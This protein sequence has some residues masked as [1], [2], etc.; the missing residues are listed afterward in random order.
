MLDKQPADGGQLLRTAVDVA[1]DRAGPDDPRTRDQRRADALIQLA[2][3]ALNGFAGCPGCV[4]ADDNGERSSA[5]RW[6]GARPNIQV[7][8]PLS[9]LLSLDEEP[10]ELDGHGPIRA[11]LARRIAADQ[12]GTWRRLVTDELGHLLD[13]GRTSYRPPTDLREFV[14]A[15]DRTCRFPTCNRPAVRC[16]LDHAIPWSDGGGTN[17]GKVAM[18]I[19]QRRSR[20]AGSGG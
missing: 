14:T 10:G 13:Y 9:T 20:A 15:R 4:A 19:A 8:V 11:E 16:E 18:A 5:P 1:A 6:Q 3:D 12:H 2:V 7:S 17:G